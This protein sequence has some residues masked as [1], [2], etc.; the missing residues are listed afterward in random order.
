MIITVAFATGVL[1]GAI[2]MFLLMRLLSR[3]LQTYRRAQMID[4]THRNRS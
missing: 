1:V 4:L 2:L 3:E